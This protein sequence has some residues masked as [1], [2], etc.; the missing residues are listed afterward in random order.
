MT[1]QHFYLALVYSSCAMLLRGIIHI[2]NISGLSSTFTPDPA[3]PV[4]YTALFDG[5]QTSCVDTDQILTSHERYVIIALNVIE[6]REEDVFTVVYSS[7][8][9]CQ[10]QKVTYL[11]SVVLS[12]AL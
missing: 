10:M 12:I 9:Y 3:T 11:I 1:L 2:A 6:S 8:V 5:N 7:A 4:E